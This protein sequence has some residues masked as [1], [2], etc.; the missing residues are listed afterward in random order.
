MSP[1]RSLP[2]L[3][4]LALTGL[5][6]DAVVAQEPAPVPSIPFDGTEVFCYLLKDKFTPVPSIAGLRDV[7]AEDLL[8]ILFGRPDALGPIRQQVGGDLA[9]FQA[10]G[11]SLLIASDYPD[12]G[13]LA[14]LGVAISGTP[15]DQAVGRAYRNTE[16]CPLLTEYPLRGPPLFGSLVGHGLATNRPHFIGL[17]D[18]G[19]AL[20]LVSFPDDC[21]AQTGGGWRRL[22]GPDYHYVV[23]V[24][25]AA[26][27]PGRCLVIAGHGLFTN[28][29]LLQTDNDN[30]DFA[31]SCRNWLREGPA[32][33]PARRHALLVVDGEVVPSFDVSLKP[34]TPPVPMPTIQVVNRLLHGL[35]REGFFIRLL[36][37]SV[38][39]RAA[40]RVGLL[41]LT[42]AL[43]LYG[44]KKLTEVRHR[45]E[46]GGVLLVGPFAAP[47]GPQALIRQRHQ[48]QIARAGLWEEA[49]A[50]A[51]Q[52]F[53]ETCGVP[54]TDWDRPAPA[55]PDFEADGSFWE[56]LRLRRQF[57]HVWELAAGRT[58]ARLTW[59]ELVRLTSTLQELAEAVHE[60]RLRLVGCSPA[61]NP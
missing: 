50:L 9:A 29:M 8:I 20:P 60:G 11:G 35:E 18:K 37:D 23:E 13:R 5:A 61:E 42:V 38:D 21:F 19:R 40:A 51:R 14:A 34:P 43:M 36:E 17:R 25:S 26:E 10:G 46:P 59:A 32:G 49:R 54:P 45:P 27:H 24:R 55:P 15:V 2:W 30:F 41:L 28:G 1:R 48:S 44:A 52:W 39:V 3:L 6:A 56:R 12:N 57:T 47:A 4:T 33:R 53:L 22:E 16:A 7:R 31:V 58:P